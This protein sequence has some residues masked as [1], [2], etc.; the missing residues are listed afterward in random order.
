MQ[1]EVS[2]DGILV[3]GV[4][5]LVFWFESCLYFTLILTIYHDTNE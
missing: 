2:F 1:I 4:L 5:V 3:S